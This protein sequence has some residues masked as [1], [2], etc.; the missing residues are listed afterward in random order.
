MALVEALSVSV[1][2]NLH[3]FMIEGTR[4]INMLPDGQ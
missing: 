4:V 3:T 2:M 1:R